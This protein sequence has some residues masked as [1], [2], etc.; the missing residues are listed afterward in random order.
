MYRAS[1]LYRV[2]GAVVVLGLVA[3]SLV[4]AQTAKLVVDDFEKGVDRWIANDDHVGAGPATK[5]SVRSV[6]GGAPGGGKQCARLD[7]KASTTGWASVSTAVD[8]AAWARAGCSTL[9]LWMRGDGKA[10]PIRVV[11]RV[12]DAD[13]GTEVAYSQ[14][15]KITGTSWEKYNLRS[16]GFVDAGGNALGLE[17]IRNL[18]MLQFARSGS[19]GTF[20]LRVDEIAAVPGPAGEEIPQPVQPEVARSFTVAPD[21]GSEGDTALAQVGVNLGHPP[22]VVEN[23]DREAGAWAFGFVSDLGPTTVRVQLADYFDS[24]KEAYNLDLLNR[25]LQWIESCRCKPLVCLAPPQVPLTDTARKQRLYSVFVS[26]VMDTAK[27]GAQLKSQ[28]YYEIFDEP[29]VSG[30]FTDVEHVVAAYNSLADLVAAADPRAVIG[31]PGF[32]AA[33]GEQVMAFLKGAQRLDFLSVHFYGTHNVLTDTKDLFE[34]A[35]SGKSVDLPGQLSFQDVRHLL[36]VLRR[37]PTEFFVTEFSLSAARDE[38]GDCRDERATTAFGAAWE[39][40]LVLS[41]TPYVDKMAYFKLSGGGWGMLSEAGQPE[42]VAWAA[43]MLRNY[44][45][46]GGSR[47]EIRRLDDHTTVAAVKTKTAY[48][49]LIAYGGLDPIEVK[50]DPRGLPALSQVRDR[51]IGN[52]DTQWKGNILPLSTGQNMVLDGPGVLVVQY[53][54]K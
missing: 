25:H 18:R 20:E 3:S 48:N 54:P 39:T 24:R 4:W 17:D 46:R 38:R 32:A 21:F 16:F 2:C 12:Y 11:L 36:K 7:F 43:W 22:T 42:P 51:W 41:A 44:A 14:A 40:A 34:S 37:R 27:R 10:E 52:A 23:L 47:V 9:S 33:F 49:V 5:C 29:L 8:G 45:P 53:V 30:G 26:A 31:G 6:S 35:V 1:R 15:L 28:R 50:V 19:W 13:T